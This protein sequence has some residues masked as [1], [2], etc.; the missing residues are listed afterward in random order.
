[1]YRGSLGEVS[2][3]ETWSQEITILDENGDDVD[4]SAAS[5]VIAVRPA[6]SRSPI[7]S[8]SVGSGI[9]VVSPAFTFTFSVS[10]MGSLCPGQY[11]VGCTILRSGVTT[12]LIV[13]KVT[14]V[15][16]IVS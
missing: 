10:Q 15:D 9:A 4:I 7:L 3:R 14:I 6:N 2:N 13:G 12:Q 11:D 1:M 5:I 8:A 16:G